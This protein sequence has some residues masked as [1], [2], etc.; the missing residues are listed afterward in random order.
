MKNLSLRRYVI[1]ILAC[2]CMPVLYVG[3]Q[4]MPKIVTLGADLAPEQ[5]SALLGRFG[6]QEG[7]DKILTISA[8]E[9][10]AAMQNIIPVPAGYTSVS[11]TALTCTQPGSGLHVTTEH[12]TRVTAGMYAGALLTAGIGDADLIVAAPA[13]AEAEGMTALTGIFKAFEG[14]ACGRGEVDPGRRELAYRWLAATNVLGQGLGDNNA[15]TQLVLRAQQ[16]VLSSG[17]GDPAAAEQ[18]LNTATAE[19]NINPPAEQREAVLDLLRRMA[20][21]KIDWGTYAGGWDLQQITPAEV[22]VAARQPGSAPALAGA[23]GGTT[24]NG[25]VR[26]PGAPGSLLVIDAPGQQGQLNL[27]ANAVAV[28]R[29]GQPAQITDLRPGDNVTIQV[30]AGN[31]AQRIDA[32]SVG[33][34]AGSSAGAARILVGTVNDNNEGQINVTTRY[35]RQQFTVPRGAYIAREGKPTDLGA[36]KAQDSVTLVLTGTD[37][38][39]AVFAQPGGGDYGVSGTVT[40]ATRPGMLDMRV[41]TQ[42]VNVPVPE[43]G[44]AISRNTRPAIFADIKPNDQVRVRFN[45]LG[46]PT[47]IDATSG[48]RFSGLL[49][50]I[51][52]GL[53]VLLCLLPLLLLLLAL[54]LVRRSR[55]RRTLLAVPVRRRRRVDPDD[56]DELRS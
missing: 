19:T 23:G 21:A 18:A 10:R 43:T 36:I 9:M 50:R 45:E 49:G 30:G 33:N 25:T 54:L 22:R 2:L 16:A 39:Q 38:V 52:P 40:G 6:A 26:A 55:S 7:V 14:G 48:G 3:A 53:L 51:R 15:A 29:D 35:N 27:N 28:T 20:Q 37:G 42:A 8:D 13:D 44:V 31:V 56:I 4:Q 24:I 11:S 47:A 32:R 34:A 17:N 46:Q 12:I 1:L 5:R 41:G